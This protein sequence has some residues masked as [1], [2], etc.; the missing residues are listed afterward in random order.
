MAMRERLLGAGREMLA[1]ARQASL[2]HRD[3]GRPRLPELGPDDHLVVTLHGLLAT[4]GVMRPLRAR[5][6]RHGVA[7]AAISYIPGPSIH[8]VAEG[9]ARWLDGV[10][11]RIHLVGHSL[12]G[13]VARYAAVRFGAGRVVQ[14]ISLASPFAGVKVGP[15]VQRVP[16]AR[17]LDEGSEVLR[18]LRFDRSIPHLSV[19]SRED[20]MIPAPLSHALP[21]GEVLVLEATGHNA[22]LFDRRVEDA[23]ATRVV[24]ALQR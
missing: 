5:L 21:G 11:A 12:G 14:T 7:T 19:I 2:L 6:E 15:L 1:Y 13:V 3:L 22:L 9:V 17:D 20:H 24:S 23:I 16:L 8:E 18:E 4:G 10:P